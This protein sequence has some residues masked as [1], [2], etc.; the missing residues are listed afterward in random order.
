M[1]EPTVSRVYKLKRR[2]APAERERA[3]LANEIFSDECREQGVKVSSWQDFTGREKFL[4]GEIDEF[5]LLEE[6]KTEVEELSSI[7]GKY[8]VM[9]NE[10]DAALN[11]SRET[12][13]K[14]RARLANRIYRRVCEE[15][16][17]ELCFFNDFIPWSDYV[18]GAISES[19]LYEKAREEIMKIVEVKRLE[20]Q[21]CAGG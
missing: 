9:K 8:M 15:A 18:K 10:D 20:H 1:T 16:G 6:A 11:L 19:E 3:V 7:Y 2:E 12:L 4:E 5:Q 17:M 21:A 13:A 14:D